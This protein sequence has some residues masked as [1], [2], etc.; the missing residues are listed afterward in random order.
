[1]RAAPLAHRAD[2]DGL[3]AVAILPILLLHC[4][5]AQ[6]RGGFVGVDIFFV[7]SGYLITGIIEREAA[8]RSFTLIAFY[9]R[10]IVRILP[11]LAV[12]MAIVLALGC[13]VM[14]PNP[15][16]DMGR[17]AAATS[18]F[19]SNF[20]FWSTSDY[21][22]AGSDAKPFIHTWSLAVEEQFYL[23]FPLILVALRRLPRRALVRIVAGAA[24]ASLA[25]GAW[26]AIAAPSAGFFLLPARVFELMAGALVALGA[27]PTIRSARARDLLC[28]AALALIGISCIVTS[29]GWPFPVPFAI[30]PVL[31][32]TVLLA[33]GETAVTARIL[34]WTPARA[35]GLISY[36]LYLWHRPV[37]A[38]YQMQH[39][40]T[41]KPLDT[42]LLMA[43]SL[44]L[45]WLS[46]RF[47][48]QPALR[49]WRNR[50]GL[51]VHLTGL[52]GLAG[53]ATAGLAIAANAD[54]I[55]PLPPA[56]M[57]VA[58]YLGYDTTAAGRAQFDTDR[59]FTIPTGK[60][61]D[62]AHCLA[63]ANDRPNVL[64]LGDSHAA[65]FSQ[66]LRARLARTNVLQA[67]AA[68]CRPLL[69]GRGLARCRDVMN[70]AFHGIDLSRVSTVVL[71]GRWLD[72]ETPQLLET[73]A[74]LR[75]YHARVI[76]I[77]PM[78]EYD[79]DMPEL[80]V[81]A[82][83]NHDRER[84]DRFRLR[85]R[86]QLDQRLE[87]LVQNAGGEYLST[88]R[89]ECPD[90]HCSTLDQDGAAP[91]FDHSHLSNGAA[92]HII[93]SLHFTYVTFDLTD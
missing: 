8:S 25:C 92:K 56:A 13:A 54:A 62:A 18:L 70:L 19:V 22:A 64:L 82:M 67:T 11:A 58:S 16:R 47:V 21:F 53:L 41:L 51:G 46:Y 32:A 42:V 48:E 34:S 84:L 40:T 57:K 72:S 24:L 23:F 10:R 83:V 68:G 79:L 29:S 71:G 89:L 69:N 93:D 49:R 37:I 1:M 3:R 61:F 26:L 73:I 17:S 20:Y 90:N 6:L 35:I 87:P 91:H 50:S 63:L 75:R 33:Y 88:Q 9:R 30:P 74:Y 77:G 27:L 80:V 65:Q 14:L 85:D 28:L 36:S 78:V 31:G 39:G 81:R 7:I 52:A 44:G 15:I 66:A 4:G 59:C 55:R 12:M 2:I 43:A 5:I 45:A 76:V 86:Q 60:P 38:F